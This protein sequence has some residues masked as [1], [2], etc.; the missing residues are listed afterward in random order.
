MTDWWKVTSF[1]FT[2]HHSIGFLFS[3]PV[4]FEHVQIMWFISSFSF[5]H[6]L[7]VGSSIFYFV[8]IGYPHLLTTYKWLWIVLLNHYFWPQENIF[9]CQ[10]KSSFW[11]VVVNTFHQ[12]LN[13]FSPSKTMQLSVHPF[14]AKCRIA[15][16]CTSLVGCTTAQC[17]V[18][19]V[20]R[21]LY[22]ATLDFAPPRQQ[23][24]GSSCKLQQGP[25]MQTW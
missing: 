5:D 9:W 22:R 13:L 18:S 4:I 21:Y 6:H 25:S 2:W 12:L 20:H 15:P 1:E 19:L 11:C 3:F 24:G 8:G 7:K 23:L 16:R 17:W 14:Q 10:V